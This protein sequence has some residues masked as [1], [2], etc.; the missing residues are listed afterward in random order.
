MDELTLPQLLPIFGAYLVAGFVKGTTGLGFSTTALPLLVL[1]FGLEASL[2]LVIIPS[3]TSNLIVMRSAGHVR[4]M[5]SRC[6][7]LCAGAVPGLVL[8]LTLLTTLSPTHATTGLGVVLVLYCTFALGR[9]NLHLPMRLAKPLFVP[10][11]LVN[12]LLNGLTG[13]QVMPVVPFLMALQLTPDR[14]IQASNIFFT[15]SSL[16]MATGLATIGF[17][18]PMTATISVAGL[19]PVFLGVHMGTGVRGLLSA[20]TFR[21]AVLLVL[22]AAGASLV[23]QAW[24]P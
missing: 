1:V 2:P 7:P 3:I 21:T 15:T 8:G 9:P 13:S 22:I 5:L 17:F 11:G 20:S 12:G 10:V 16:V 6:W 24:S 23:A 18:P 19:L 14:F 4:E